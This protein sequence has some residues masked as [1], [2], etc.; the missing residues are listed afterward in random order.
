MSTS[1]CKLKYTGS[2]VPWYQRR[3]YWSSWLAR[4]S[5]VLFH[6]TENGLLGLGLVAWRT[7]SSCWG[8]LSCLWWQNL[9]CS[10]R[11]SLPWST[12]PGPRWS[13]QNPS[14]ELLSTSPVIVYIHLVNDCMLYWDKWNIH[15]TESLVWWLTIFGAGSSAILAL[16]MI[17]NWPRPPRAP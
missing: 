5:I 4:G 11:S 14:K 10:Q 13:F 3:H 16:V 6:Q 15:F 1:C 12:S 9:Q 2:P 8:C 17:P 7:P